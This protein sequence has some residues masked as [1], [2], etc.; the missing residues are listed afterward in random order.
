VIY[1]S[2]F[3]WIVG[4]L[5]A[6]IASFWTLDSANSGNWRTLLVIVA[7]PAILG[8]LGMW[9]FMEESPRSEMIN[10]R[11]MDKAIEILKIMAIS[12]GKKDFSI[13]EIEKQALQNW[14]DRNKSIQKDEQ[15]GLTGI[16]TLLNPDHIS[17]T[18]FIWPIC[19]IFNF[20]YFG[21]MFALPMVLPMIVDPDNTENAAEKGHTEL[22]DVFIS[23]LGEIPAF[24]FGLLVVEKEKFGRRNT[25]ILGLAVCGLC[26]LIS[27]F[28]PGF[29]I[30]ILI[31]RSAIN[32]SFTISWIFLLELYPT[33][34]RA[35]A[36]GWASSFGSIG[37]AVMPWA[38]PPL[39]QSNPYYPFYM[40]TVTAV[41]GAFCTWKIRKDTTN[42]DLDT[43]L[44]TFH[45]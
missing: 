14:V 23:I 21:I 34:I 38:V 44:E 3:F 17:V 40:F 4:E 45:H 10:K 13:D 35:T 42:K 1:L 24:L 33:N 43:E 41:L 37:G 27:G 29:V 8:W 32:V 7:Q 15:E 28:V 19:F 31:A 30:W 36:F 16:S 22:A 6:S 9:K 5:F 2:G 39:A 11:D 12:N 20:T 25:I 18:K 26:C